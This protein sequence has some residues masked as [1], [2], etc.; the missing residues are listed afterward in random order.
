MLCEHRAEHA[1]GPH[2]WVL[3]EHPTRA[4][5]AA[6]YHFLAVG[7]EVVGADPFTVTSGETL[8]K[9]RKAAFIALLIVVV[10]AFVLLSIAALP[11][12]IAGLLW[13]FARLRW[14][15]W[16]TGIWTYLVCSPRRGW[17]E[18]LSNNVVPRLPAELGCIWAE[19]GRVRETRPQT[20]LVTAGFGQP[21]PYLAEVRP[22][23][24][25]IRTLNARLRP[26][27]ARSKVDEAVQRE[28]LSAIEDEL[29]QVRAR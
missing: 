10:P 18:L 17:N 20:L 8:A 19:R 1:I 4:A 9:L 12:V 5:M 3:A 6:T 13:D 23:G 25:R 27:K 24:V 11:L 28:V 16:R 21:K 22:M 2:S 26:Y 29:R 15:C 7:V 14:H